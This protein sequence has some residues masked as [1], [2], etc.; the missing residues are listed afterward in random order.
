[1]SPPRTRFG[2]EWSRRVFPRKA[3]VSGYSGIESTLK[4]LKRVQWP[5]SRPQL[6]NLLYVLQVLNVPNIAQRHAL[7]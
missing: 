1:M 7:P 3:Q 4:V 2:S 6:H 5:F